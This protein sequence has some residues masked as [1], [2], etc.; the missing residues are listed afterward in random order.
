M[1][2]DLLLRYVWPAVW[3]SA[4]LAAVVGGVTL[5]FRDRLEPRWRYLLW[6]VVLARLALPVLPSSPVGILPTQVPPR[7]TAAVPPASIAETPYFAEHVTP[8]RAFDVAPATV[9]APATPSPTHTTTPATTL[10]PVDVSPT[11]KSTEIVTMGQRFVQV[12]F[13]VWLIGALYF[14]FR[15]VSGEIRLRYLCRR[16]QTTRDMMLNAMLH[17]CQRKMRIRRRVRLYI[18]PQDI[19]AASCG[20]LFPKILI[21]ERVIRQ[22]SPDA[23]RFVLLH[24]LSH[25]KRFDPAVHLLTRLLTIA[26]WPNPVLWLTRWCMEREREHACDAAVLRQLERWTRLSRTRP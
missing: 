16:V 2:N 14:V 5:L 4:I 9:T 17:E 11:V 18:V 15:Y 13:A 6:A 7:T 10:T 19:N 26:Y 23:L 8:E 22:F 21:S 25:I 3:Q 1:T 12:L 20:V 24:E